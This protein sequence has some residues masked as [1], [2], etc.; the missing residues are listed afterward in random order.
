MYS[1]LGIERWLI[2]LECDEP[3]GLLVRTPGDELFFLDVVPVVPLSESP[4]DLV[5]VR[6]VVVPL[7][8]VPLLREPP[9][10]FVLVR[11]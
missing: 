3:P 11:P 4:D 2:E 5:L 6:V 8:W 9:D 7:L 10:D 1:P